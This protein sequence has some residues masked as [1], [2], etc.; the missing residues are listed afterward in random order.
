MD[1]CGEGTP[2]PGASGA[3]GLAVRLN[4]ALRDGAF[5]GAHARSR[6]AGR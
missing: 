5:A 1:A 4:H 6:S 3:P 2:A